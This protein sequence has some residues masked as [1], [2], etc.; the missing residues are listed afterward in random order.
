MLQA[1]VKTPATAPWINVGSDHVSVN[2][3]YSTSSVIF[4]S[5]VQ[6][7]KTEHVWILDSGATH[8][9][10]PYLNLIFNSKSVNSKLHIPNGEISIITHIGQIQLSSDILLHAV[11]VVQNFNATYCPFLN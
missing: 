5:H 1:K 3:C 4:A 11:L 10:T 9:I 6:F 7:T 8:H 2:P